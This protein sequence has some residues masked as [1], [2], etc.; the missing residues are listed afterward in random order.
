MADLVQPNGPPAGRFKEIRR[1][2]YA[3]EVSIADSSIPGSGLFFSTDNEIMTAPRVNV[4]R[5]ESTGTYDAA[6]WTNVLTGTG[7]AGH[8]LGE[9]ELATGTTAN[10]TVKST[11]VQSMRQMSGATQYYITVVRL[12][13]LGVTNNVRRWGLY[14]DLDGFFYELSGTVFSVVSRKAGVDTKVAYS[15]CNG[16]A[17]ATFDPATDLTKMN[18]FNLFFGGLSCRW[19]VNGRVLHSIGANTIASPLTERLS[20][21]F[22]YETNNSS[23]QTANAKILS[24]GVS[25]H[26]VSPAE[27]TPRYRMISTA[28]TT[29]VRTGPGTLRRLI[30]NNGSPGGTITVYDNTAASGTQI[31]VV[32]IPG[33]TNNPFV[34]DYDLEAN[35]GITVVTSTAVNLTV[36]YD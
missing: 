9:Y 15:A 34:L 36:T 33:S 25:F 14:D 18:Q 10:S 19:Q 29:V 17:T 3:P 8:V 6:L 27:V 20:L 32:N 12:S 23:G 26:R 13:D 1:G 30:V 31:A 35:T 24:R 16:P 22:R 21:P 11:S 7:S 28:T 4:Y 5:V 2:E